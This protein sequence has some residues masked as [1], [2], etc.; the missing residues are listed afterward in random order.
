MKTTMVWMS[1]LVFC[2]AIISVG[3]S[4]EPPLLTTVTMGGTSA[5]NCDCQFNRGEKTDSLHFQGYKTYITRKFPLPLSAYIVCRTGL[6]E[7]VSI[8]A[9]FDMSELGLKE[10]GIDTATDTDSGLAQIIWVNPLMQMMLE[11]VTDL[12]NSINKYMEDNKK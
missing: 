5:W 10:L 7:I 11:K 6:G 1:A 3:Q 12:Q 9:T 2:F 8:T 4:E